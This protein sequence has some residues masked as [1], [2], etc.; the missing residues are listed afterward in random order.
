LALNATRH[1][2]THFP[3]MLEFRDHNVKNKLHTQRVMK[4]NA[5]ASFSKQDTHV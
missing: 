5:I 4:P 3:S 1:V 2:R